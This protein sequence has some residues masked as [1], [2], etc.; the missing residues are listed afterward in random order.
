MEKIRRDYVIKTFQ[1]LGFSED[2]RELYI[3]VLR[4][5]EFPFRRLTLP[6]NSD[7]STQLLNIYLTDLRIQAHQFY[8]IMGRLFPKRQPQNDKSS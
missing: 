7:I 1:Q 6:N 4:E 8:T 5:T 3:T 2:L